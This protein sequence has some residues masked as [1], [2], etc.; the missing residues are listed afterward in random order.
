MWGDIKPWMPITLS[1]PTKPT[2]P[3]PLPSAGTPTS[4]EGSKQAREVLAEPWSL[5]VACP[6]LPIG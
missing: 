3:P 1:A 2:S 5:E 4:S 6:D